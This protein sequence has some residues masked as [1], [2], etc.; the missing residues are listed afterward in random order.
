MGGFGV[1]SASQLALPAFLAS[2]FGP[3]YILT[4]IFLEFLEMFRSQKRLGNSGV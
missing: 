1:S 2:A 4:T 3:G